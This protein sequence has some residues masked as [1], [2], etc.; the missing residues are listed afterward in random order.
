LERGDITTGSGPDSEN[1][2][3]CGYAQKVTVLTSVVSDA[4]SPETFY[5]P[6]YHLRFDQMSELTRQLFAASCIADRKIRTAFGA[7]ACE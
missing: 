4:L 5:A 2:S 7:T 3:R 6:P 1:A